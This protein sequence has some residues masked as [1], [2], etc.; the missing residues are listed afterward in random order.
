MGGRLSVCSTRSTRSTTG[1]TGSSGSSG[2]SGA[3]SVRVARVAR[4]ARMGPRVAR[5][6]LILPPVWPQWIA[7]CSESLTSLS[8][9]LLLVF[10]L[11]SP[12]RAACSLFSNFRIS[13]ERLAPGVLNWSSP[14]RVVYCALFSNSLVSFE[15]FAQCFLN[16]LVSFERFVCFSIFQIPF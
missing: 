15:G 14:F 5:P 4:V 7:L 16:P 2:A 9:G 11:L 1:A 12:F 10:I 13:L 8:S 6:T 3:N